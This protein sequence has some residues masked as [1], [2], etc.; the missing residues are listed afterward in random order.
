MMKAQIQDFQIQELIG[1]G[2]F[3]KVH[4]ALNQK[5]DRECA[6]KILEKESVLQMKQVDHIISERE[7]LKLLS[8]LDEKCPFIINIF[9]SFQDT[10]NLYFELEYVQ[11]CTLLNQIKQK[12]PWVQGNMQFYISEVLMALEFL[13]QNHIVYRDLKPENIVLSM[14][15]RGHIKLVDFGF[16]KIMKTAKTITNCG[17]PVYIAPEILRGSGHSYQVDVW[18]LGILIVEIISGQTPF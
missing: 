12:N 9:S 16:A 1:T 8:N 3:G 10:E 5:Q 6:L 2:N 18:S 11:G 17:T 13:H 14:K 4:K 15:D 7:I